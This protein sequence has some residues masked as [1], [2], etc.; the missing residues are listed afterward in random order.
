MTVIAHQDNGEIADW[1]DEMELDLVGII[2]PS[3]ETPVRCC[4][5]ISDDEYFKN[6]WKDE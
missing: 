4:P 5:I 1:V 3:E 2:I 6:V